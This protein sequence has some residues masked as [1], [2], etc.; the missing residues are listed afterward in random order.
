MKQIATKIKDTWNLR[1]TGT[2]VFLSCVLA[3]VGLIL[4]LSLAVSR[5]VLHYAEESTAEHFDTS[6]QMISNSVDYILSDVYAGVYYL[7]N[8]NSAVQ[9]A[10][11]SASFTDAQLA[12]IYAALLESK[13]ISSLVDSVYFVNA[14]SFTVFSSDGNMTSLNKFSDIAALD[15]LNYPQGTNTIFELR[16][17]KSMEVITFALP[18]IHNS[19]G[20]TG[21]IIINLN[22][23]KVQ[24]LFNQNIDTDAY[25][26]IL[27]ERWQMI[28]SSE[29]APE[30]LFSDSELQ[31]TLEEKMQENTAFSVVLLDGEKYFISYQYA[32]SFDLVYLSIIP[33][34]SLL[35]SVQ[36]LMFKITAIT[37]V[38]FGL[39]LVVARFALKRY[40]LPLKQLVSD[41]RAQNPDAT[42]G[43][44]SHNEFV[45]LESAYKRLEQTAQL[46]APPQITLDNAKKHL[47]YLLLRNE[48]IPSGFRAV[49]AHG[50][51]DFPHPDFR[52]G[53]LQLQEYDALQSQYS[54]KDVALVKYGIS[55]I[56]CELFRE[57]VLCETFETGQE[58]I[59]FILNGNEQTLA[60]AQMAPILAK[61][62]KESE[63]YFG[64]T[65]CGGLS[66]LGSNLESIHLAYEQAQDACA[67]CGAYGKVDVLCYN[68][69]MAQEGVHIKYPYEQEQQILA[70]VR[71]GHRTQSTALI[72]EFFTT[73][74]S[75]NLKELN[76]YIARLAVA[77][78]RNLYLAEPE[79]KAMLSMQRMERQLEE[80]R[81]L[82]DKQAYLE[83]L[84][85]VNISQKEEKA[86][87]KN[88]DILLE[89]FRYIE[90]HY[91]DA[92][93]SID[94]VAE[95][96]GYSTS[97]FRKVFKEL[98]NTSFNEYLLDYRMG[99]AKALLSETEL[100]AKDI[101]EQVGCVN[102]KYFY[103]VFKKN[104]G[105]TTYEYR[106]QMAAQPERA[107]P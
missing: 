51:M 67:Y 74:C 43:Q 29:G 47:L 50:G 98:C 55:N 53:I 5:L 25:I 34:D 60:A 76:A 77:L 93:L 72:A 89:V 86:Q 104:T 41:V 1:Q 2:A 69:I 39:G 8:D 11:N 94:M 16:T 42:Q 21:G 63:R 9:V 97:Y 24:D 82:A 87:Y 56:G 101:S 49:L 81:T 32:S 37:I 44:Q 57:Q 7:Y 107:Q 79:S 70:A 102:V 88:A 84:A 92:N 14:T 13:N 6:L 68:R 62:A 85:E 22:R 80:R 12:D 10:I 59:V 106:N 91:N 27:N 54:A 36:A 26:Y 95:H 17:L 31:K 30:T 58:Y 99:K 75:T 64:V 18:A 3:S 15:L 52:V 38:I 78:Q 61:I 71:Q 65:L 20:Q 19:L 100:T 105:M 35:S 45:F 46:A 83:A 73:L 23:S 40:Y 4:A 90:E 28:S 96:A 48:R 66:A 103:S 33:Y